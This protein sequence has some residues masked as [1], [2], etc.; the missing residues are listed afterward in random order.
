MT[1]RQRK[2]VHAHNGGM[3]SSPSHGKMKKLR[4]KME[5][6]RDEQLKLFP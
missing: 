3:F 2:R 6:I 4:V 1:T 5:I